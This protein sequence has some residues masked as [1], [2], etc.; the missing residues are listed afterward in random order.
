[1]KLLELAPSSPGDAPP[2]TS[3]LGKYAMLK[4]SPSATPG[5]PLYRD[6][7]RRM[8]QALSAGEWKSGDAI[9]AERDLG[10][11]F[12]VSIGTLRRAIDELVAENILI[13]QQ[14]RGTFVASHNRDAHLFRFFNVVRH[15][16]MKSY[17]K[18]ELIS[19]CRE[20]ASKDCRER[21]QLASGAKVIHFVN[22]LSLN[23]EAVM[24]DDIMISDA[25]FAG[26]T[27]QQLRNRPNT[28]YNLYQ[29]NF[30]VNVI[31]IEERLRCGC[32]SAEQ[33]K[34]LDLE[35]GAGLLEMHR[36]AFSFEA[37]PIEYRLS[38]LNTANY[39]YFAGADQSRG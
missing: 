9:P 11:R 18:V 3:F 27:E 17:P 20:R 32:A 31:R 7:A 36:L 12:S 8:M 15:D 29:Q 37:A 14:G 1:M 35:E 10:E 38:R 25:R 24:L 2:A 16:G 34:L 13:R 23:G 22:R 39:E 5:V 21:L 6:V 28:I 26:L 19:F 30:D 33:A 4:S